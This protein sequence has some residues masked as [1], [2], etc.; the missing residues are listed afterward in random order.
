MYI[1]LFGR[2]EKKRAPLWV[3][4]VVPLLFNSAVARFGTLH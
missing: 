2:V 4:T 1:S 3:W